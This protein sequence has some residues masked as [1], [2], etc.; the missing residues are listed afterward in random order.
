MPKDLALIII[1]IQI[2]V[3]DG[4][5][6]P[7][8]SGAKKLLSNITLLIEKA[9]DAAVPIIFVQHKGEREH[10]LEHGTKGWDFHPKLAVTDKDPVIQK[11]TPDSFY[12]TDLQDNLVS[13]NI[14]RLMIAGIQSEFCIDTTCRQAF[15]LGYEV[16]LIE[17]AHSTWDTDQLNA[18]QIINH[19]N[20]T[21]SEWFVSL[22]RINEIDFD[23]LVNDR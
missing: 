2:G 22:K 14:K 13:R 6:I 1:D 21:L 7:P 20:S 10:P 3:F 19:H 12:H 5:S 18:S 23:H 15:S 9:R 4:S 11:S 8:V 17:D 16:I